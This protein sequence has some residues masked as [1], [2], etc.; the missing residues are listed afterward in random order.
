MHQTSWFPPVTRTPAILLALVIFAS[1]LSAAEWKEKVLYSFQG[2]NDGAFPSGGVIFDK[3]GDLYGTTLQGGVGSCPP[4]AC[5][6]VFQ[7]SPPARKGDPWTKTVL[8]V[9]KGRDFSDGSSPTG[10][11]VLDATGSLY[12]TTGYGGA[13]PCALFGTPVGCGTVFKLSPPAKQGD[14]WTETVLYNFQGGKDGY[15]PGGALTWDLQGNLYGATTFGGGYG[16]CNKIYG[17]CGTVF[18]LSPPKAKGGR[19][20]EKVLHSFKGGKD[21]ANPLG[22][23]VLN[24]TGAIFGSTALGGSTNCQNVGCGTLFELE[25]P[26][27]GSAWTGKILHRFTGGD[28]GADPNGGLIFDAK[29]ALYGTAGGGGGANSEGI[30][31]RFTQRGGKWIETVLHR[32]T[33]FGDAP[34]CP[35]AGIVFDVRGALYGGSLGGAYFR[36]TVFRLDSPTARGWAFGLLYTM[37]G[38]PDAAYPEAAIV[39]DASGNLYSTTAGGGTGTCSGGCG[40]VFELEP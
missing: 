21:G 1:S 2:G 19:W 7:L 15:L 38:V 26:K 20:T 4:A 28:D 9:F 35:G 36:G 6:T 13:G 39:L 27:D 33:G 8:Y 34:C 24:S 3:H 40:T 12:G 18:E 22:G 16:T 30:I 37:K 29:G 31:F 32:F 14:A 10:G 17:F 5:G 25:P 11:V 23:L